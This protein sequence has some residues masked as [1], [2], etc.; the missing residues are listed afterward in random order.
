MSKLGKNTTHSGLISGTTKSQKIKLKK[1]GPG[2]L[3][4]G[5]LD[6]DDSVTDTQIAN[7]KTT[8]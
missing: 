8:D 1:K 2:N 4:N 6:I 3:E 5:T 7:I